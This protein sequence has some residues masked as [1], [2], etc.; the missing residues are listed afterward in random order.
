MTMFNPPHP[1]SILK[2]DVLPELGIDVTEAA[3]QL[4]MSRATLFRVVNGRGYQCRYGDSTKGSTAETWV[5]MQAE[6]DFWQARQKPHPNIKNI[7][8]LQSGIDF[9][10][11]I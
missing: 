2:E 1:G 11:H 8:R 6:Y 4:G 5:R 7:Y 3:A 9:C 10:K